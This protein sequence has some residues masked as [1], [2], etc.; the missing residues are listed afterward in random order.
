[1]AEDP[2]RLWLENA[3][4]RYE[5]PLL[6]VCFCCL[7]EPSLA[8][9]ALQETFFKAWKGYDR[10]RREADEKTWL[11]RIA[12]N[13]CRNMLR[14]AWL[15]RSQPDPHPERLLNASRSCPATADLLR[16]DTVTLAVLSLPLPLREAVVLYWYQGFSGDEAAHA[17]KIP[18]STL[19]AR[20]RRAQRLLKNDLED[21]YHEV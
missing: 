19:Y 1:M 14:S 7:K 9:D 3:M 16:D 6:R 4:A 15:R 11:M 5:E 2:K 21:W 12:I 13:T 20:L 17:L 18:R 10:F 8:E